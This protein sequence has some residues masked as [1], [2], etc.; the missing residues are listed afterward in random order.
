MVKK[1]LPIAKAEGAKKVKPVPVKIVH[2]EMM[3]STAN[4]KDYEA[5]EKR[6]RAEEAL[7]DIERAE[8][9]K[10]DKE[11]MKHVKSVAKEKIAT[12]NKV[13]GK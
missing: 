2:D 1:G 9:H 6:Y 8:R 10:R 7:R 4:N 11:L 5:K 3:P 13:C 12:M